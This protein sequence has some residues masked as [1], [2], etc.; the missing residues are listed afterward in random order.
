MQ[1]TGM[2]P[3]VQLLNAVAGLVVIYSLFSIPA[4][5]IR[6]FR[7]KRQG[8]K[9]SPFPLI[10]RKILKYWFVAAV[11]IIPLSTILTYLALSQAGADGK[12]IYTAGN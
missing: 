5:F 6:R 1:S 8:K 10:L 2:L 9:V 7:L 3:L 12:D 11:I 4:Q